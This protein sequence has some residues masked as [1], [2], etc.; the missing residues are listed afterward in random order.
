MNMI[1]KGIKW[2]LEMLPGG[3]YIVLESI[4][5]LSDNTRAVFDEM[6]RRGLNKKYKFCWWVNGDKKNLPRFP[7][8][9]YFDLKSRWSRL[10][11]WWITIRAKCLICCN[12]FLVPYFPSRKSFYLTHGTALKRLNTYTLPEGM[13]YTLVASEGVKEVMARELKGDIRTFYA[14][15]LPRNDSL[16]KAAL[17]LHDYFDGDFQKVIVWYPTFRQHKNGLKT[18]ARNALPVLHDTQT[19]AELNEAARKNRVLI[20][21]KPH[22]AQ[23]IRYISDYGMSNIR[24][25][26]DSFFAENGISSYEFVGSCDA[27]ITD[28]SSI[29]FDYLLCDKPVAVVWE[30]IE[31]YRKNPGFA[32]DP[33]F[34]MKGAEKIYNLPDF[35]RFLSNVAEGKDSLSAQRAEINALVNYATDGQNTKRVVDFMIEKAHL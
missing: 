24:F 30:D 26:D 1:K 21:V 2:I 7:N 19:A 23:D 9:C 20:V 16:Q 32:L 29:Y 13:S 10:L 8:T 15:G 17:N 34:Y 27:L 35:V 25:I 12:N 28:Y 4:P 18:D 3:N 11:F 31:D 6:L 5:D 14:L 33:D 22:F